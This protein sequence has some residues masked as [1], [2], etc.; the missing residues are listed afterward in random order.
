[1]H[2]PYALETAYLS[3]ITFDSEARQVVPLTELVAFQP[4][5][6]DAGSTTS[7]G[8][9][10]KLTK[11][12]IEREV[13]K[14]TSDAKGDW[15][16]LVFLMTDGA[17]TDDWQKGLPAARLGA[18]D[19]ENALVRTIDMIQPCTAK[20]EMGWHVFDNTTKPECPLCGTPYQGQLPVLNFYSSRTANDFRSDNH[21]LMVWDGQSLFS[22]HVN[23][24]LFP[25]E[26][27]KADTA[28]ASAISR[29]TRASGCS[30]TRPCRRSTMQTPR[31]RCRSVAT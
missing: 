14:T 29:S 26:H 27:L 5:Q 23:R 20:C 2:R 28:S 22:W 16:P 12:C 21:R 17:P 4:P 6:I 13:Q 30:S 15:K 18:N 8:K 25:N 19:W 11:E 10:L 1:V 9:A 7:L 3:V 31:P 24:L